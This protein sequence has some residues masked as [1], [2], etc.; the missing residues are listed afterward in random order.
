MKLN[1]DCIRAI[2]LEVEKVPYGESLPFQTLVSALSDYS[3]DDISYSVLKLKEADYI[4][5][6]ILHADDTAIIYEITDIT[7]NGHQFL[8]TIRDAKVWKETKKICNKVGSFALNVISSVAGQMLSAL[9]KQ[10][11]P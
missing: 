10:N 1:V 5:A 2:L 11:L 4:E 6:I 7:Y 8:E 3:T 9:V